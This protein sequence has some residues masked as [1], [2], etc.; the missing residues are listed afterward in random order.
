MISLML[1]ALDAATKAEDRGQA[2][3][4]LTRTAAA[5]AVYRA[6]QGEYPAKLNQLVPSVLA[7]VPLDLY[8]DKPF[9]YERMPDGG[10]LLY[11]LYQN[12]TDDGGTD[13]G[14]EILAGE[15]V[16]ER[17]TNVSPDTSD[18]VIRVPVPKF[19]L[20]PKPRFVD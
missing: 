8:T 12:G 5:L 16:A 2:L 18:L 19:E 1:P 20:P 9:H 15:W 3:L 14:G 6:E 10:Y 17:N 13:L 4:D 7:A 11:S